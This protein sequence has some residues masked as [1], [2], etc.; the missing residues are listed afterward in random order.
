MTKVINGGTDDFC[1]NW[2][3]ACVNVLSS[4]VVETARVKE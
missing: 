4:A 1:P 2:A 3:A